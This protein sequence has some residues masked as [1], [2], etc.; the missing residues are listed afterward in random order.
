MK[1]YKELMM[2]M[3]TEEYAIRSIALVESIMGDNFKSLRRLEPN[4]Q[5]LN[6]YANHI[7]DD[8]A[9][10]SGFLTIRSAYEYEYA[11]KRV[12][13]DAG[14]HTVSKVHNSKEQKSDFGVIVADRKLPVYFEVKTTQVKR[15]WQ[16]ATHSEGAGK[17][18]NYILI[19]YT[20]N[21]DVKLPPLDVSAI[22]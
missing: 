19:S 1:T 20:L 13:T 17:V 22:H 4:I 21:R 12:L 7:E 15:G 16:G 14:F 11:L 10:Q 9:Q 18:D 5:T 3:R 8:A 2:F 6:D